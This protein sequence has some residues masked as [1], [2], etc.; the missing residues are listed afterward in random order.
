MSVITFDLTIADGFHLNQLIFLCDKPFQTVRLKSGKE[1]VASFSSDLLEV[2]FATNDG[3]EK[4]RQ[5]N[6]LPLYF[7][8][9]YHNLVTKSFVSASMATAEY[10]HYLNAKKF[11]NGLQL[12]F[13]FYDTQIRSSAKVFATIVSQT[14]TGFF[15]SE[16]KN[17]EIIENQ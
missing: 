9:G 13:T 1:V 12:E 15:V 14:E 4:L 10:L 11:A 17:L 16:S 6:F 2:L 5:A 8:P 7:C 3:N